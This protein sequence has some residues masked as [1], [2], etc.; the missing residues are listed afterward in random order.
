MSD[1]GLGQYDLEYAKCPCFWGTAPG[2]FVRNVPSLVHAGRVLDL[3]AGEGKNAIYLAEHGFDVLAVD[4]SRFALANFRQRLAAMPEEIARRIEIVEADVTGF[5][6]NG[7]F[8]VVVAYGLLHCLTDFDAIQR[9]VSIMQRCTKRGGINVLVCFTD[10][11]PVPPE[12]DYL[13]PTLLPEGVLE[14]LYGEWEILSCEND[15]INETHPT[16]G[17][18]HSHSLCRL[19]ARNPGFHSIVER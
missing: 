15:V 18:P 10:H 14:S 1:R 7:F 17:T 6:P 3:G 4:C 2:K 8:D 19:I 5:Q 16:S 11:L 9:V 13:E 12:Q